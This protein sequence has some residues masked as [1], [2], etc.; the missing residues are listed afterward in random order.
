M[1]QIIQFCR[2]EAPE[3][4]GNVFVECEGSPD[5]HVRRMASLGYV[6]VDEPKRGAGRL[7]MRSE[8]TR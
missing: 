3:G 7:P 5:A 8:L 2:P 1:S 6:M 4:A